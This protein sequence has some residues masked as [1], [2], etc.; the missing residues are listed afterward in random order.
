MEQNIYQH[1]NADALGLFCNFSSIV[2]ASLLLAVSHAYCGLF[3]LLIARN[4]LTPA[5]LASFLAIVFDP[6]QCH[7]A[8][9]YLFDP[10]E[11]ASLCFC[12]RSAELPHR[13]ESA[14]PRMQDQLVALGVLVTPN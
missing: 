8:E 6:A 3:I 4:S 14:E 12:A 11:L 13:A 2:G 7:E 10:A 1:P 5:S 9:G